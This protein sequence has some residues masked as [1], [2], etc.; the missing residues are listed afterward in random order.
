M[1]NDDVSSYVMCLF[2]IGPCVSDWTFVKSI[3]GQLTDGLI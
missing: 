2:L 3:N 1:N